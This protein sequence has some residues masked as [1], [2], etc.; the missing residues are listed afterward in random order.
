MVTAGWYVSEPSRG[1]DRD[2][3]EEITPQKHVGEI[4]QIFLLLLYPLYPS[5]CGTARLSPSSKQQQQQKKAAASLSFFFL[6]HGTSAAAARDPIIHTEVFMAAEGFDL[7]LRCPQVAKNKN[8]IKI[9]TNNPCRLS[10]WSPR[11]Y[12]FSPDDKWKSSSAFYNR[13]TADR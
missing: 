13:S 2:G 7:V 6:L 8:K 4:T 9:S 10:L 11:R 3:G 1:G 5:R 12:C